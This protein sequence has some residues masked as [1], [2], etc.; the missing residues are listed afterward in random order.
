MFVIRSRVRGKV[1]WLLIAQTG[2]WT[3]LSELA[4]AYLFMCGTHKRG[5]SLARPVLAWVLFIGVRKNIIIMDKL[6][7]GL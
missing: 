5:I 2:S 4:E 3:F 6:S 1:S 7:W